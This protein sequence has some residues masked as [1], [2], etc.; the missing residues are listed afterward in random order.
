MPIFKMKIASNMVEEEFNVELD[1]NEH[2][3]FVEFHEE[4]NRMISLETFK[5]HL[6][7]TWQCAAEIGQ[8]V[9]NEIDFPSQEDLIIILHTIRPF[10]LQDERLYLVKI[11]NILTKNIQNINIRNMINLNRDLFNGKNSQKIVKV[12]AN[13]ILINSEAFLMKYL[14]A[15]EYHRDKDK[16]E[17]FQEL[18][19]Y[20]PEE[21]GRFFVVSLIIDKVQAIENINKVICL[22]IG[23]IACIEFK[24]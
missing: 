11:I 17:F 22:I 9:K 2:K 19:R 8:E 5:K 14:N 3:I 21:V 13:D 15:Y 18:Y 24:M 6:G 4:V 1:E 7:V 12:T 10:I 23:D 16:Q 20:F